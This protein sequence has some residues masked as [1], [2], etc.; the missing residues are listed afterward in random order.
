M[1]PP[2]LVVP[3][4][5]NSGPDHWQ[6]LWQRAHPEWRRV[7]QRDWDE[8]EPDAWLA[9]LDTAVREVTAST[10]RRPV[11]VGHSLGALLVPLWVATHS[12]ARAAA[13]LLVAPA[14]VERPGAPAVLRSFAPVPRIRLP[15]PSLLAASRDDPYLSW[16][17][18]EE[19]AAAWGAVLHDCG[20]AGHLNAAAGFGPW[21]EGERLLDSL[22]D[23][24][25]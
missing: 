10:G 22:V 24:I 9:A 17:R 16:A 20:T 23:G 4:W 21:P 14:D 8:P 6:S 15:F 12:D 3:G 7:E 25:A 5:T 11:L 18:A 1:H 13:A 2:V 19:L